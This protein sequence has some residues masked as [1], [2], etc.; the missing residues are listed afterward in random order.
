MPLTPTSNAAP[1]SQ[2]SQSSKMEI[3]RA[4]SSNGAL[5]VS[6]RTADKPLTGSP[7]RQ[8]KDKRNLDYALRSGL[9]GGLAG[10]AVSG[11]TSIDLPSKC[12]SNSLHRQK[13]LSDHLIESKSFSKRR[14][15]NSQNI[16][17][18]GSVS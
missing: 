14:I 4:L 5:S 15:L 18:H 8:P 6:M 3:P 9:A 11:N 1:P 17:D 16:V 2:S 7:I 12:D 13:R 10:C